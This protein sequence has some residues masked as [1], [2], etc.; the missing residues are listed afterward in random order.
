[1]NG[2]TVIMR[3]FVGGEGGTRAGIEERSIVIWG[4]ACD[5]RSFSVPFAMVAAV[6]E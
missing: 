6:G 4:C 3:V 5:L 1:M 2:L